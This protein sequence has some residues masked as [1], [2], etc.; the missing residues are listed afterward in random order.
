MIGGTPY[1]LGNLHINW[2][3]EI[4]GWH[5][6]FFLFLMISDNGIVALFNDT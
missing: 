3:I 4:A 1:D 5:L 2:Q 6:Q